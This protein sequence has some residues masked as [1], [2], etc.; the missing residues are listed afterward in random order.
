VSGGI[1]PQSPRIR[2]RWGTRRRPPASPGPEAWPVDCARANIIVILTSLTKYSLISEGCFELDLAFGIVTFAGPAFFL[3]CHLSPLSRVF[4]GHRLSFS[5]ML[6]RWLQ[7]RALNAL[8]MCCQPYQRINSGGHH[9]AE[10]GCK[11][12]APVVR[13]FH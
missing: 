12:Q 10:I 11:H 7:C 8:N 4:Q 1:G 6:Q 5:S 2:S 9:W 13:S 3:R